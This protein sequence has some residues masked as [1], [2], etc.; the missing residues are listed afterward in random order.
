MLYHSKRKR[1]DAAKRR[2]AARYDLTGRPTTKEKV[3]RLLLIK[4]EWALI[5]HECVI[6]AKERN[7]EGKFAGAWVVQSLRTQGITPPNNL[8]TL[9]AIGLLRIEKIARGG[10]RAY[11]TIPNQKGVVKALKEFSR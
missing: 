5:L 6:V 8:R 4:P 2:I 3:R 1:E 7:D 9:T 10:N 11:Y